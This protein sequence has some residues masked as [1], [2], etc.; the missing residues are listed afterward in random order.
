MNR[1]EVYKHLDIERE[2]QDL[3]WNPRRDL[4]NVG[5]EDLSISD[6]LNFMEFHLEKAK[7]QMYYHKNDAALDEV[8]KVTALGVRC[9]ELNGCPERIIPI[10]L[11]Q[12]DERKS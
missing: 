1:S 7:N 11:T 5:D 12:E 9:L 8:R 2:Y 10:E 3:K 6:W 4:V